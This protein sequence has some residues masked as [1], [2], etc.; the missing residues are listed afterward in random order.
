MAKVSAPGQGIKVAAAKLLAV[1]LLVIIQLV[2][3]EMLGLAHAL[4]LYSF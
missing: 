2:A 1:P 4:V 3:G